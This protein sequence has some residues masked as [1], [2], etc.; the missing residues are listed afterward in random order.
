MEIIC[1]T[2][3]LDIE[4]SKSTEILGGT[5]NTELNYIE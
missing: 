2:K 3:L 4:L 5:N 1:G